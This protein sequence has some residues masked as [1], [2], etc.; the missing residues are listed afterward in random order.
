MKIFK[1]L[2]PPSWSLSLP[3]GWEF[4]LPLPL[5]GLLLWSL[6]GVLTQGQLRRSQR[7]IDPVEIAQQFPANNTDV[8]AGK[9]IIRRQMAEIEVIV[10]EPY[11]RLLTFY[12]PIT[13]P[14]EIEL[15]L[16]QYFNQSPES[17]Q[18]W[19]RFELMD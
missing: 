7:S 13:D 1:V 4:W 5:I 15:A 14:S 16:A 10:L 12:W 8:L 11:P 9:A 2:G 17:V 3:L 19:L 18:G 6:G